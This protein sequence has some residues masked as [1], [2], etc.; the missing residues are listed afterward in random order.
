M[1]TFHTVLD[2]SSTQLLGQGDRM[3]TEIGSDLLERDTGLVAASDVHDV[4]SESF[5]NGLD[6]AISCQLTPSGKPSSMS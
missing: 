4:V 1:S 2:I 6:V 5:G 3:V